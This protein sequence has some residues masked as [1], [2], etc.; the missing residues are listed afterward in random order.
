MSNLVDSISS[1][2]EKMLAPKLA[3]AS[4]VTFFI[5]F[6]LST[7][8]FILT[9][10]LQFKQI[11]SLQIPEQEKISKVIELINFENNSVLVGTIFL[12][13]VG[14]LFSFCAL[15]VALLALIHRTLKDLSGE[16]GNKFIK[17][18][19]SIEKNTA[20]SDESKKG[21]LKTVQ[22]LI[23]IMPF[24]NIVFDL[25]FCLTII[26]VFLLLIIVLVSVITK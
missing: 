6:C 7:I 9:K 13:F 18:E 11:G 23:S 10:F 15:C 17:W 1:I 26:G 12:L 3:L 20:L 24:F 19:T 21:K 4:F 22:T 2:A 8:Y 25:F 5:S 14:T 16:L